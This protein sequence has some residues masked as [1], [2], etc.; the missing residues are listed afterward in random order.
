MKKDNIDHVA[1][2]NKPLRRLTFI[3]LGLGSDI[4]R[5]IWK[6]MKV[7][8]K[9]DMILFGKPILFILY[10]DIEKDRVIK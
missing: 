3:L 9:L 10:S 8:I 1:R 4:G 6:R 5:Y 2:A 7:D